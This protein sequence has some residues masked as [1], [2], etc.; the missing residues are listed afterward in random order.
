MSNSPY[1]LSQSI[2]MCF[3]VYIRYW[4]CR[5]ERNILYP[6]VTQSNEGAQWTMK[7]V[8]LQCDCARY[9]PFTPLEPVS[10]LLQPYRL[11][12]WAVRLFSLISLSSSCWLVWPVGNPRMRSRRREENEARRVT[13]L[14]SSQK[15]C[16][17]H[18]QTKVYCSSS[19]N[20]F[21]MIFSVQ[22]VGNQSL[23]LSVWT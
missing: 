11:A 12:G 3:L 15:G 7:T 22:A 5:D 21:H 2:S 4:G 20:L 23:T 14:F 8:P 17:G 6:Q 16:L 1:S 10:T 18:C 9:N 19:D 13:F